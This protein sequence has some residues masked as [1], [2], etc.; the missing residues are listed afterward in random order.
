[1]RSFILFVL[2]C[3]LTFVIG[4]NYKS[5]SVGSDIFQRNNP[6]S[7]NYLYI[8][9]S[10][11]DT[12]FHYSNYTR[13]GSYIYAGN[14]QDLSAALFLQF[15]NVP[16]SLEL[17]SAVIRILINQA[18]Y[19]QGPPLKLQVHKL[20]QSWDEDNITWDD[21][22]SG[23]KGDLIT[24]VQINSATDSLI[25][26]HVPIDLIELWSDTNRADINYGLS[27]SSDNTDGL[28]EFYS[29]ANYTPP[30][31]RLYTPED[32]T[33]VHSAQS[34]FTAN[35]EMTTGSDL[36]TVQNGTSIR[37]YLYFNSIDLPEGAAVNN[38]TLT[39]VTDS[40]DA[41][42]NNDIDYSVT[43][44]HAGEIPTDFS[45]TP[46]DT[47]NYTTGTLYADSS[48]ISINITDIVQAWLADTVSNNGLILLG[49]YENTRISSRSFLSTTAD[50][51]KQ[52]HLKVYYS[53]VPSSR[54]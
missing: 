37:S 33:V 30:T 2:S 6:G 54:F 13:L 22:Q 35:S 34:G 8:T 3:I 28:I 10:K 43:V 31:L 21:Y 36:L 45:N 14:F 53:T 29:R 16:D 39:M 40:T 48:Q 26:F 17:D 52:P 1:M 44:Y 32:T 5:S 4:C 15:T 47:L 49:S 23:M 42:P 25:S 7:E 27:I 50:S 19:T 11:T 41:F 9:P 24:E 51:T 18:T 38:A 20:A 46:F 12:S